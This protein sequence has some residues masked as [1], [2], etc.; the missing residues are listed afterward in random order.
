MIIT[1]LTVLKSATLIDAM[2]VI[3]RGASQIAFVVD[4]EQKLLG[5]LM[6]IFVE[7]F[8]MVQHSIR[9]QNYSECYSTLQN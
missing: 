3:E 6:V 7:V 9:Q 2:R 4:E 5:T 8:C 1:D